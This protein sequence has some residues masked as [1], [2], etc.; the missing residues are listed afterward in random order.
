L[1]ILARGKV[2]ARAAEGQSLRMAGT[3][4]DISQRMEDEQTLRRSE[5]KLAITLHSIGDAVIATDEQ[6]IVTRINATGERLSCPRN[7][8]I[9]PCRPGSGRCLARNAASRN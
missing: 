5:R 9:R 8:V 1:W 2:L 7:C 3:H 4:M 6:S